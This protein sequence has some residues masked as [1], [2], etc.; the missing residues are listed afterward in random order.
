MK[1]YIYLVALI[2]V[3]MSCQ[4]D[5]D[6]TP[7]NEPT[8]E[9]PWS[10]VNVSGGLAGVDQDFELGIITW[11]F[12]IETQQLTIVNTNTDVV[13][14]GYPSGVYDFQALTN[15]EITT[16]VI[17]DN[18]NLEINVLTN[19]QLVLDEGIAFDGFLYTFTR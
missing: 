1:K 14:D 10:L 5:D 15:G 17:D 16:I 9:G 3:A 13:F 11:D 4:N 7:N 6:G 2:F 8:L 18:I 19:S 12:D